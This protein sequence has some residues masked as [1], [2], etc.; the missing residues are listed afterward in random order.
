LTREPKN[1]ELVGFYKEVTNITLGDDNWPDSLHYVEYAFGRR[2]KKIQWFAGFYRY[3]LSS[4]QFQALR[5]M[6][7]T[8]GREMQ[9]HENDCGAV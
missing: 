3:G 9:R 1:V 4:Y 8:A 2:W 6:R 7:K 5:A